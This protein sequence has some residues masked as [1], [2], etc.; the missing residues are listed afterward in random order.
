MTT[1]RA[2]PGATASTSRR[3]RH[4]K[5]TLSRRCPGC[6]RGKRRPGVLPGKDSVTQVKPPERNRPGR[7]AVAQVMSHPDWTDGAKVC[8]PAGV[9]DTDP[10]LVVRRH[11]DLLRVRSAICRPAR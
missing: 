3:K 11:V 9:T 10:M 5:P 1:A 4:R 2:A 8:D 7:C 6:A